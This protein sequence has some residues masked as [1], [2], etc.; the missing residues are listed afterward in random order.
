MRLQTIR[1]TS[2]AA[3]VAGVAAA[4]GCSSSGPTAPSARAVAAHFDSLYVTAILAGTHGD[5]I[6]A[7]LM[8]F[9]E[10]AA[11]EGAVPK[12]VT[13]TTAAGAQKWNA[14]SFEI[15]DTS[16]SATASTSY[17]TIAYSDANATNAVLA[18]VTTGATNTATAEM[19]A[20]DTI[21]V[22]ETTASALVSATNGGACTQEPGLVNPIFTALAPMYHC[23]LAS[24]ESSVNATWPST[25]GVDPTLTSTSFTNISSNGSRFAN[26]TP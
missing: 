6:R 16:G 8:T 7:R 12:T 11:G 15:A 9:L 23:N 5:S 17:I 2:V 18:E 25:A 20:A 21:L 14:L 3:V 13:M 19:L 22:P 26:A 24:F 1:I 10:L 4:I